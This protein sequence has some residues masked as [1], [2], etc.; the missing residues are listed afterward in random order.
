MLSVWEERKARLY[1]E[2]ANVWPGSEVKVSHCQRS[3]SVALQLC[4]Q[5]VVA[6]QR[7]L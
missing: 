3:P 7:Q 4:T 1:G 6:F 2:R 5:Q